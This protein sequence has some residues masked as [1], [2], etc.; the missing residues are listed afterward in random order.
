MKFEG[1]RAIGEV[2]NIEDRFMTLSLPAWA[3]GLIEAKDSREFNAS[4]R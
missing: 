2:T 4:S 3:W 1:S